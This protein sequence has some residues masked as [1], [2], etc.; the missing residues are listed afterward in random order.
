MNHM[1]YGFD[2][3]RTM[4]RIGAMNMMTHGVENPFIEYR[5]S[6][7]EQN[8]DKE[9]YSLILANPP[10]KGSLD[11]DTVS[12]DLLKICKTKKTELLF[13]ALF[14][15]MLKTGED[16]PVLYLMAYYSA[17]QKHIKRSEKN[18]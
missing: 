18:W 2:M 14:L 6:L 9:K 10:F 12:P 8:P 11:Y 3:D 4:L 13:L 16:V 7:S 5:D 15:R 1:F 17:H